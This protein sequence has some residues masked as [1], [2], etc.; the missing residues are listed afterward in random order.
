MYAFFYAIAILKSIK[1]QS[2]FFWPFFLEA[3]QYCPQKFW[4]P[5]S[6]Q[7]LRLTLQELMLQAA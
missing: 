3:K 4:V 7:M 5:L 1:K 6:V 2:T